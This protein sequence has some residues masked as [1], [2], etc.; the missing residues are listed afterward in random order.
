MRATNELAPL[1]ESR[2]K[3]KK[4]FFVFTPEQRF[5]ILL[6]MATIFVTYIY[7]TEIPISI[8]FCNFLFISQKTTVPKQKHKKCSLSSTCLHCSFSSLVIYFL[9]NKGAII[10]A[11]TAYFQYGILITDTK[12]IAL[13]YFKK[14][15][16]IDLFSIGS[17]IVY[18]FSE[19]F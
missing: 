15:F 5:I 6:N 3:N 16:L 7:F 13:N 2:S 17:V 11:R 10:K 4:K 18:E 12:L 14:C 9:I 1:P 8:A 19:I